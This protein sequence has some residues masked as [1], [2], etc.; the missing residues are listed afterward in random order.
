MVITGTCHCGNL[1]IALTWDPDP[2][3]LPARACGCTFCTKHGGV[4]TSNPAG[5]LAITVQDRAF[6]S[7]YTFGTRTADFHMCTRCGVVPVATSRI[8]GGLY[9]VVNVNT[10]DDAA[11]AL[12]TRSPANHDGET[13][14]A[15]L[16]RRKRNWIAKVDLQ[17]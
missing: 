3:E 13:T 14:E 7:D 12:V 1:A 2:R 9:A 4:W 6:V 15:R 16:A 11:R 8:D 10:F 17:R 5:A